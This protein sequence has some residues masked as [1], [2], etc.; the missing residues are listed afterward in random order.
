MKINLL[1]LETFLKL[2]T[3]ANRPYLIH[4]LHLKIKNLGTYGMITGAR[5]FIAG[6]TR[7]EEAKYGIIDFG[8]AFEKIIL[9]LTDLDLGTCWL[10]GTFKRKGFSD[11]AGLKKSEFIPGVTPVGHGRKKRG[12]K[13]SAVRMLAGS[14]RRKSWSKIFFDEDFQSPLQSDAGEA[15]GMA[16]EMVRLGPSASNMQPWRIV[17]ENNLNFHFFLEKSRAYNKKPDHQNLQYIDMGISMCHFGL[18]ASYLGLEG[19]WEKA[20]GIE[21][22]SSKYKIPTNTEYIITWAGR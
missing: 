3:E 6:I 22:D 11:R 20:E 12:I 21:E 14:D 8:Y 18:T 16:L 4:I 15:Y 13:D 10:G 9:H 19:K 1:K 7:K 17:R 5:Y 2:P